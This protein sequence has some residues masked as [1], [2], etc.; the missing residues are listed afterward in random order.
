MPSPSEPPHP[1]WVIL[2]AIPRVSAA[3][4]DPSIDLA[5][6]PRVSLLTIPERIFPDK[7]TPHN[8][9]TLNSIWDLASNLWGFTGV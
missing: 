4:A 6:P 9:R 5:A 7:V 8:V 1:S 2:G 3:A